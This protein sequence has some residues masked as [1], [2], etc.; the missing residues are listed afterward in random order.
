MEWQG[1]F[2]IENLGLNAQQKQTLVAALQQWGLRNDAPN[3]RDRNHW[4]VR[5]DGNAV[6]FEAAFDAEQ[7]TLS[8]FEARLAALFG[9]SAGQI[10]AATSQNQYGEVAV[11]SY[12]N[13]D[14]LRLG[15]FGGRQAGYKE[16]QLSAQQFLI[17][18][19]SDWNGVEI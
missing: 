1:Y 5:P 14:R 7:L 3:P 6:I 18:F 16:S 9:V 11:F 13:V 4:R 12:N 10:G 17:A 19:A 8:S 15:V 2:Y